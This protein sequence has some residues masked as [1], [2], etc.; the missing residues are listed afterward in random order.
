MPENAADVGAGLAAFWMTVG[1][2]VRLVFAMA[3]APAD[4]E[5]ALRDWSRT[6]LAWEYFLGNIL[7]KAWSYAS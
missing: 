7:S 1:Y 5:S 4:H 3:K 6:F 2:K